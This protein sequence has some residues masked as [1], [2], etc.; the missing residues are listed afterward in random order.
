MASTWDERTDNRLRGIGTTKNPPE[1][2]RDA[3]PGTQEDP[4]GHYRLEYS[5]VFGP[6]LTKEPEPHDDA[7]E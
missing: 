7:A 6:T 1:E 3:T 2:P 4:D 5:E